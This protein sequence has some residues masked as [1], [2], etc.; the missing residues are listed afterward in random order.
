MIF[1]ELVV[2]KKYIYF[3]PTVYYELNRF[4]YFLTKSLKH[5]NL[6]EK[7]ANKKQDNVVFGNMIDHS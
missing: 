7:N 6:Q 3:G 1:P 2:R 5:Y 4:Y